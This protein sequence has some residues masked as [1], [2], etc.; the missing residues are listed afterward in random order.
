[1][2]IHHFLIE[3]QIKMYLRSKIELMNFLV[4]LAGFLLLILAGNWLLKAAV[5]LSFRLKIPKFIVGMTVVSFATSGPEL[6]VSINAALNGF[7]DIA[8][9][10]VIGSNIANLGL[11]LGII[12]L[13]AKIEVEK[14]FYTTDWSMMVIASFLFYFFLSQDQTISSLEGTMLVLLLVVFLVYLLRFQKCS[15]SDE[16]SENSEDIPTYQ[17]MLLL[18]IGSTG[19]WGGSELLIKGTV[20]LATDLGVSERMMS[21]SLVSVGTSIPE[22]ATSVIA[23]F[24]KEK[25]ISLGN[26]LG[27]NIF[28]ILAVIGITSIITPIEI[29]DEGLYTNDIQWMLFISLSIVFLVLI[30]KK[31]K[32]EL[33]EGIFLLM[34]YMFFLF[35]TF[36]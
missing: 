18:V 25:V 19:L 1:M 2:E 29:H 27:S 11:V 20:S 12:L 14:S 32:L 33:K 24:K 23:I 4:V 10:N 3:E 9:G 34:A 15:V 7:S 17:T 8:I 31:M 16:F 36:S 13:I 28:N 21:I 5:S 26:L 35:T 30:P 6:V 22:L